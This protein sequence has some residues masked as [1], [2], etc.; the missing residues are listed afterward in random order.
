[1]F[2]LVCQ[3][4]LAECGVFGWTYLILCAYKNQVPK[5]ATFLIFSSIHSMYI[6]CEEAITLFFSGAV[7]V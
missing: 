1:M 2:L 4:H 3:L 6:L 7:S 5:C